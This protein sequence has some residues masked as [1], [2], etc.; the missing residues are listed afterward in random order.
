[1]SIK[2]KIQFLIS[3]LLLA[4]VNT[5]F[6]IY[7]DNIYLENF[8]TLYE[9]FMWVMGVILIFIYTIAIKLIDFPYNMLSE[10]KETL[11]KK[12]NFINELKSV[13]GQVVNIFGIGT[14]FVVSIVGG[15]FSLFIPMF[16]LHSSTL[17]V[18]KKII[19]FL[20]S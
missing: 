11:L 10:F 3:F 5:Y 6:L 12:T 2:S 18:R 13:Y 20:E 17:I 9:M 1:M 4:L 15:N 8:V 14:S 19:K 16:V 7:P